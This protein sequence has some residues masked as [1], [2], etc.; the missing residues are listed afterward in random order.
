MIIEFD[1][2]P[3]EILRKKIKN[4]HLRIYPPDGLVKVSAPLRFSEQLIRQSLESK[5]AWIHQQRERIR[6]RPVEED[7]PFKMGS[8][9]A[10]QGKKYLLIIEE[11]HGPTQIKINN[12]LMYC[13]T[14]PNSS[15]AQIQTILER[16]YKQQMQAL[17]PELIQHWEAVIGVKVAEWGI[18]K[19]KTRWGSCNTKAARIWLNLNLI[20]KSS[21][22]LEYVLVHELIHL[23]EPSH[24]KRFYGLMSK[25]MPQWREYEYQLEGRVL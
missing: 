16:W 7:C 18:R 10:F 5:S 3:I 13:Y 6:N 4:M 1:G 23:L 12:E 20:K 15:P 8:T 17:L 14:Q 9:V 19:M 11:H 24:N 2:I 25:F 22:C 21:I